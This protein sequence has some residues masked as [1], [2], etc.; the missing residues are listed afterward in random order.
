MSLADELMADLEG[1][2]EEEEA[3][4]KEEDEEMDSEDIKPSKLELEQVLFFGS[5]I[6]VLIIIVLII[7]LVFLDTFNPIDT[8]N[9]ISEIINFRFSRRSRLWRR[10]QCCTT[11][12]GCSRS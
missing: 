12:T 2:D 7:T 9:I 1:S 3:E 11:P 4:V 8:L 10:L 6:L 5:S